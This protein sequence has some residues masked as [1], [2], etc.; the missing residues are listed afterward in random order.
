MHM[1]VNQAASEAKD[2]GK[3]DSCLENL[4][5]FLQEGSY[6]LLE[7]LSII[8]EENVSLANELQGVLPFLQHPKW[9]EFRH[10]VW[11]VHHMAPPY[12]PLL[13]DASGAA[14]MSQFECHTH[15]LEQALIESKRLESQQAQAWVSLS[16]YKFH[17]NR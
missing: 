4:M 10:R 8:F 12:V 15:H 7:D 5:E 2:P 1:Q 11:E 9:P 3:A 6:W 13:P 14:R 16:P 17:E